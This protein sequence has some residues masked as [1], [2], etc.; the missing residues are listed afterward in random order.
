MQSSVPLREVSRHLQYTD[1]DHELELMRR[2]PEQ[3]ETA[4]AFF[5]T[6]ELLKGT[7]LPQ[8]FPAL[9][10][11]EW[12][13]VL[14][15]LSASGGEIVSL[16][17][18]HARVVRL[19]LHA[20]DYVCRKQAACM[21]RV[22]TEVVKQ[23]SQTN[24]VKGQNGSWVVAKQVWTTAGLRGFYRGFGSTVAREVSLLFVLSL[25]D[26]LDLTLFLGCVPCGRSRSR[27][28]NSLSTNG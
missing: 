21:I 11:K 6:Y 9:N 12:A 22:P 10:T 20:R 19:G 23:R 26:P 28:C 27:A 18:S 4:A 2:V 17:V 1:A 8:L 16:S 15:M 14:H 24:T 5:T 3:N 25:R 13:P 7:V